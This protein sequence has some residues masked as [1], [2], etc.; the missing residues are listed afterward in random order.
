MQG[1]LIIWQHEE[2]LVLS[3]DLDKSTFR[4]KSSKCGCDVLEFHYSSSY[5]IIHCAPTNVSRKQLF[6]LKNFLTLSLARCIV[7]KNKFEGVDVGPFEWIQWRAFIKNIIYRFC[8]YFHLDLIWFLILILWCIVVFQFN[9][10]REFY[11]M[12]CPTPFVIDSVF[13]Q[14]L[15]G[16]DFNLSNR[17]VKIP[18]WN[19]YDKN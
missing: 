9:D 18:L 5:D 1:Q 4:G 6:I 15:D 11:V 7:V 13:L 12:R 17:L 14:F 8:P 19:K 10:Y 3:N 16:L 2:L